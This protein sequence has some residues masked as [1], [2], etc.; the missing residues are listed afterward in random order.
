[1]SSSH[2]EVVLPESWQR[3][4][5]SDPYIEAWE[6]LN[7]PLPQLMRSVMSSPER[8]QFA[9]GMCAA[10]VDDDG[11]PTELLIASLTA[12]SYFTETM[13]ED[14]QSQASAALVN[15][16]P[17]AGQEISL[18]MLT[19]PVA[20]DDGRTTVLLNFATPNLYRAEEFETSFRAIAATAIVHNNG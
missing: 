6:G 12:Y 13:P 19:V 8:L 10:L 3:V 2:L 17:F 16:I 14:V 1:M 5:P 11:T 7:E 4:D 20:S 9:A 18:L 15:R